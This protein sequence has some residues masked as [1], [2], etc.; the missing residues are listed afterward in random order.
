MLD[1]S[2][3]YDFTYVLQISFMQRQKYSMKGLVIK[4]I[5]RINLMIYFECVSISS[6]IYMCVCA[7]CCLNLHLYCTFD[8]PC[9]M[10]PWAFFQLFAAIGSCA[11]LYFNLFLA[12]IQSIFFFCNMQESISQIFTSSGSNQLK[13]SCNSICM[14]IQTF[15]PKYNFIC[16][17]Y[18][19]VSAFS[20]D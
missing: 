13:P 4:M 17:Y 9:Y 19:E 5:V 3:V 10:N 18:M 12:Q 2:S 1:Q 8:I 20:L 14:P 15:M 16:L 6:Y 7:V 11:I